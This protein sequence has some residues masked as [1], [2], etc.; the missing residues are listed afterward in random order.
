M[1]SCCAHYVAS[2]LPVLGATGMVA[3]VAQY[4][5]ALFWVRLAFIVY[6]G[7]KLAAATRHMA[8]MI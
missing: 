1:I 3:L 8:Q 2:V 4:Q 7:R 6:V 5:T